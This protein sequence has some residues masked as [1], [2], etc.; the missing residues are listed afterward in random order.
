MLILWGLQVASPCLARDF[1]VDFVAENYRET[2][3]PYAH[4]PTVYHTLQVRSH[5]GPKLLVLSG[6]APDYRKWLRQYI[7]RDKQFMV[8]VP[9]EQNDAFVGAKVFD[10]DVTRVH[11]FDGKK[12]GPEA[13]MPAPKQM[14]DTSRGPIS[15]GVRSLFGDQNVMVIDTDM[16]RSSLIAS[17]VTRM[18]YNAMVSRDG[19]QALD[20]FR[21]QPEKFKMIIT[22]HGIKGMPADE[23]I[24]HLLKIDYNIP[25]IVETGYNKDAVFAHYLA[26]FSGVGTVTVKPVVLDNLQ[27]TINTLLKPE[28]AKS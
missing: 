6:D 23:L 9:D 19:R 11:P 8:Q 17:I 7:A 16:T 2:Q 3:V 21:V 1:M 13:V 10:I 15:K 28:K 22:H 12:W 26:T 14:P 24:T 5:A 20:V 18:G 27:R 25:I 4:Q